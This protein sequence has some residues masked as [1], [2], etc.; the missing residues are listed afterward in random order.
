LG[1]A[2]LVLVGCSHVETPKVTPVTVRLQL[3]AD[4]AALP[5]MRALADAYSS[6]HPNVIFDVQSGNAE[7]VAE[8]V[9]TRQADLAVVSRLPANVQG[10]TPPW[11]ADLAMDAVAVVV[12]PANPIENMSLQDL[13]DVFSGARN[14]WSDFGVA[15]LEDVE[16]AVREEGDGTRS[17]FDNVVMGN[18]KLTLTAIVLP[19][20]EVAMNFAAYQ[21]NAIAYVPSARITS[22]VSPAVKVMGVSG[23]PPSRDNIASGSYPLTRMLNMIALAEPQGELRRFVAWVLGREGQ[24]VVAGLNYV[25][26]G[27]VDR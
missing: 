10:R 20:V 23:I 7:T 21:A 1:I 19:S 15:G 22:T 25:P 14:R 12:N 27:P 13:R 6:T 16:V 9:Y 8:A 3:A 26:V 17:V 2:L 18:T 5:L 11:V 4:S 24:T